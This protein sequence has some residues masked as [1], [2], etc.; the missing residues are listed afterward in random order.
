MSDKRAPV[1][2]LETNGR[3]I[4][5]YVN[6]EG[7][8]YSDVDNDVIR[9]TTLKEL[10]SKLK[11]HTKRTLNIPFARWEKERWDRAPGALRQGTVVGVHSGNNNFLVRWEN[12]KQTTQESAYNN[13]FLRLDAR[14]LTK[15]GEMC[16]ALEKAE[17]DLEK[18]R[19]TYQIDMRAEVSK[20]MEEGDSK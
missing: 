4:P 17:K 6:E 10:E 2:T 1:K 7:T 11:R 18:F 12:E 8:F 16:R 5:V 15:Y 13:E 19:E 3:K 9:A 14:L 20:A